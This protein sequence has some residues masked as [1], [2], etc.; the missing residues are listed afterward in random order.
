MVETDQP[1]RSAGDVD[2]RTGVT[3]W[4]LFTA[5]LNFDAILGF[6]SGAVLL[7]VC[8]LAGAPAS[9][10]VAVW[11]VFGAGVWITS[12]LRTSV[13]FTT[14]ALVVTVLLWPRR[15]PWERVSSVT[16]GHLHEDDARPAEV[17][18]RRVHVSYRRDLSTPTGPVPTT[19]GEFRPWARLHFRTLSLP[20]SFP[21]PADAADSR[22]TRGPRTWFGRHAERQRQI[23]RRE[24]AARG[25]SLPD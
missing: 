19:L 2:R 3:V 1:P 11:V 13:R 18:S 24:F 10:Q 23:I 22:P 20:L 6:L 16:F 14:D 15:V 4:P 21:P 5:L 12:W 7:G 8:N 17:A 9:V 25:Y